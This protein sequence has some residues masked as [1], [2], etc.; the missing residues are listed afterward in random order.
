M[1][2]NIYQATVS[3]GSYFAESHSVFPRCILCDF[4]YFNGLDDNLLQT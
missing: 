2:A 1:A 3:I 4:L